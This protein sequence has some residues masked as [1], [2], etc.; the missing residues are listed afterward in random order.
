MTSELL[1]VPDA[2]STYVVWV[3]VLYVGS[4]H[5]SAY[6]TVKELVPATVIEFVPSGSKSVSETAEYVI[7]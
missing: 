5:G 3:T 6:V 7:V 2:G 4:T 1:K